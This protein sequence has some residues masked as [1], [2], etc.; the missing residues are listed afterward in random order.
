MSFH[1][2]LEMYYLASGVLVAPNVY[3]GEGF[4]WAMR[5]GGGLLD[6]DPVYFSA[7][8]AA[9]CGASL[10]SSTDNG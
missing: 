6:S 3:L 9:A 7:D 5:A 2:L 4:L 8:N 10:G 1:C